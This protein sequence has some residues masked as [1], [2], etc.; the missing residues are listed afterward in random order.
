MSLC[1]VLLTNFKDDCLVVETGKTEKMENF[2]KPEKKGKL[3]KKK[4][5]KICDIQKLKLIPWE[6]K[7]FC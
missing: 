1:S 2:Q 5:A 4:I 6:Q 7:F 3:V